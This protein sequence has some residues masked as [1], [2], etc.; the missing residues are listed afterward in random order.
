MM[1]SFFG[2]YNTSIDKTSEVFCYE[3]LVFKA[4]FFD[5]FLSFRL[6]L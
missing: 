2:S 5:D 3:G 6:Q 1:Y 4:L